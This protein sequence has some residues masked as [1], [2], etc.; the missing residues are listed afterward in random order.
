M[1]AQDG[2]RRGEMVGLVLADVFYANVR[3]TGAVGVLGGGKRMK[4]TI[5][6]HLT[7]IQGEKHYAA[8]VT[9]VLPTGEIVCDVAKKLTVSMTFRQ[10]GHGLNGARLSKSHGVKVWK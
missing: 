8:V 9:K 5:G 4:P 3:S 1:A 10:D 2:H 6:D 7:V